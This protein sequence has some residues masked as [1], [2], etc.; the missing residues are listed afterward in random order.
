M[1]RVRL[2]DAAAFE[3]VYDGFHR[4]VFG[5]ALRMLGDAASAED[6][7]QSVFLTVWTRPEAFRD[8]NLGAWLARVARNRC[9]DALRSRASRPEGEMPVDVASEESLDDTIFARLVCA[10]VRAALGDLP[11]DQREPIEMGFFEGITHE[12]IARR[13]GT[14]LGTI[15]TRI[16]TGLRKL[17]THLEGTS[18]Q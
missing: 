18:A 10:D 17:R 3:A 12:E 5:I 1:G 9:L 8:G 7:V 15:K 2:R 11:S 16:R 6:V 14:P 4:L 13:T